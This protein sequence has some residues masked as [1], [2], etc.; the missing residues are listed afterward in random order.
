[1]NSKE[2][3]YGNKSTNE[4]MK[5]KIKKQDVIWSTNWMYFFYWNLVKGDLFH[6]RFFC[7]DKTKKRKNPTWW[8]EKNSILFYSK[9][10]PTK[11]NLLFLFFFFLF[12]FVVGNRRIG[13]RGELYSRIG[14]CTN[15]KKKK[16]NEM[17]NVIASTEMVF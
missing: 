9:Q 6:T 7:E 1:M 5:S 3:I 11:K 12:F 14:I 13:N 8:N 15:K 10:T 16:I 2:E 4:E 17:N